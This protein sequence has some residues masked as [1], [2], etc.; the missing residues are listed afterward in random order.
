MEET[1]TV[2]LCVSVWKVYLRSCFRVEFLSRTLIGLRLFHVCVP[3]T[4][5]ST[6]RRQC[7]SGAPHSIMKPTS[8]P[9]RVLPRY[10]VWNWLVAIQL[11]SWRSPPSRQIP[12]RPGRFY[13]ALVRLRASSSGADSFY[14]SWFQPAGKDYRIKKHRCYRMMGLEM[15]TEPF[16]SI[17]VFAVYRNSA[18]KQ[19]NLNLI[20]YVIPGQIIENNYLNNWYKLS[21]NKILF[22]N[23]YF[24]R[25]MDISI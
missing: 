23:L 5:A 4:S 22:E 7:I 17:I 6:P 16:V 18:Y 25:I 20:L 14:S 1:T 12:G 2:F 15:R 9:P 3:S 19:T 21:E 10:Q 8:P 11:S 13:S 24:V